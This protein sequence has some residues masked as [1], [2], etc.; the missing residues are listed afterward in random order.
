MP[1]TDVRKDHDALTLTVEAAFDRP[2]DDV[3]E[4]WADPRKLE[5][6]WGPPTYPATF[7]QHDLTPG[8][9]TTYFM[10]GPEG[11]RHHGWW[12]ITAVDAP[13]HLV[14]DDGFGDADGNPDPTMPVMVIEVTLAATDT[15]TAMTTVTRFPSSEEMA[16]IIEMGM[17]EGLTAAMGQIDGVLAG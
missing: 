9:T 4:I 11:D 3:W 15:G 12:R 8:S 7:V 13:T 6:W 1:V 2:V 14:F 17:E 10:T 16:R 5:R